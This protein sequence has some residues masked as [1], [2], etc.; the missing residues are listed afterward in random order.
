MIVKRVFNRTQTPNGVAMI[1][2][3]TWLVAAVAILA[4]GCA[5]KPPPVI[6]IPTTEVQLQGQLAAAVDV[7]SN[8][9]G[10]AAPVLVRVYELASDDVFNNTDFFALFDHEQAVLG[11][12]LVRTRDFML[13]PGQIVDISGQVDPRTQFIGVIAALKQLDGTLWRMAAPLPPKTV[14]PSEPHR[15]AATIVVGRPGVSLGL[16]PAGAAPG[17]LP[18]VALPQM[19]GVA[20]PIN[21]GALIPPANPGALIPPVPDL[22]LPTVP[23]VAVPPI[24]SVPAPPVPQFTIPGAATGLPH[25][26]Q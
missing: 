12:A 7:N 17:M 1:I 2:K 3:L 25:V 26:T 24:P 15:V 5:S 6:E 16:A 20:P 22:S 19:P 13:A 21:P 23:T 14:R 18:A 11:A 4:A 10:Q 9:T 8:A